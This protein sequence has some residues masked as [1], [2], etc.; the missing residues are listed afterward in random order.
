[1]LLDVIRITKKPWS[2]VFSS[3]CNFSCAACKRPRFWGLFA[4]AQ[5]ASLWICPPRVTDWLDWRRYCVF[6]AVLCFSKSVMRA[7]P[8]LSPCFAGDCAV[9]ASA[10][11]QPKN[12]TNKHADHAKPQHACAAHACVEE[13]TVCTW[14]WLCFCSWQ[15]L[16]SR[17]FVER[18]V[19]VDSRPLALHRETHNL[20]I[21]QRTKPIFLRRPFRVA[22]ASRSILFR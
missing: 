4:K 22:V 13:N 2:K 8:L 17:E 3:D 14:P 20:G 10:S 21:L 16:R 1:M 6:N 19:V 15:V 11:D 18:L 12:G 9:F 7:D 5:P